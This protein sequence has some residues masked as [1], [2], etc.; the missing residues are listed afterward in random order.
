MKHITKMAPPRRLHR[1]FDSQ[2]LEEGRRINC[3]YVHMPGDV[4]QIVKHQLI[5][6][7]G[8]LCCYTGIRINNQKSHIEHFM[9]QS[10]CQNHEDVA[11]DNLLAAYP[12]DNAQRC[13]YG[14]HE[15]AN[16]YDGDLLVNPLRPDSESRFRF[17]L[18][19]QII[20]AQESDQA[21][22]ETIKK[23]CLYHGSLTEMRKQAIEAALFHK[24]QHLR[25]AQLRRII[26]NYCQRDSNQLFRPFCFVIMQAAQELLHKV[27]DK[28]QDKRF[29]RQQRRK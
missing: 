28:R 16:W 20:P 18:D 6:E 27:E 13:P 19:G 3:G 21:A 5:S 2:P 29:S 22:T 14:A 15:K 25:E 4:K 11:Y 23:L 7:Q 9:P 12:G 8:G 1:W 17:N 26:T 10:L 24:N